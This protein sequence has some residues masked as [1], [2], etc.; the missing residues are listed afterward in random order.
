MSIAIVATLVTVSFFVVMP[1]QMPTVK[2]YMTPGMG[3]IW[4]FDDLVA[5]SGGDVMG[6]GGI[7]VIMNDLI[8]TGGPNPD[9]VYTRDNEVIFV[10]PAVS[11][12]VDGIFLSQGAAG[13]VI[14]E[15]GSISP[16]PGDWGGFWFNVGSLGRFQAT[17]IRHARQGIRITDGDVTV[18]SSIIELCY[19]DAIYF[20]GG[21]LQVNRSVIQGAQPPTS[22]GMNNG[23][24][25]IYA[26]GPVADVLWINQSVIV[27]GDGLPTGPGGPAIF[28]LNLNGPM[29]LIGNDLIQGGAGGLN[30]VDGG[31]AGGGGI[32]F[33][34]FPVWDTG[35]PPLAGVNISGNAI[36]RGGDGGVNNATMDGQSGTGGPGIIMSDND[37]VGT[38]I[39]A[40]N[41]YISGGDGGDNFANANVGFF[42]G[43][44]GVGI[45]WDNI[46]GSP[47][48]PSRISGN[49]I[50][51]GGKGGNN[52]GASMV[53]GLAAG[54]GGTA[55]NFNDVRSVLV[56]RNTIVGGHG[57]N[58]TIMGMGVAAGQG[59]VALAMI[60]SQNVGV[61]QN[62]IFGGEGGDDYVG[63][64]PGMVAGPGPGGIGLYS[65]N[66]FGQV[67][68]NTVQGGEGG[69]NYGMGG[70]GRPGGYGV[71]V[72]GTSAPTFNEGTFRGGKGGDNY[73]DTGS[74][75][76][77]GNYA[78]FIGSPRGVTITNAEIYGGAGGDCYAGANALPGQG[79]SAI[80]VAGPAMG[81]RIADN[82][83]ITVG[84][85]GNHFLIPVTGPKG[86]YGVELILGASGVE[87]MNN[88]IYNASS[89]GIYSQIPGVRIDGN[90]I[91]SDPV[92]MGIYLD[93]T[94]NWTNITNNPMI[95]FSFLG[96]NVLQADDVTIRNNVVENT[97]VGIAII[98]SDRATIDR[99]TVRNVSTWGM[100]FQTF[101]DNV[102]VENCTIENSLT[103]D[104]A[105][106]LWS[107]ATT[108]NTT[109][110][111][112]QVDALPDTRL[113]VKNYLDVR[114]ID[115]TLAPLPNTDLEVLDNAVQV[116]ATPLFGGGDPTTDVS[117]EVN[118]IVVTDRIYYGSP[119]ATENITD[120]QVAE[121]GRTFVNNPRPVDMSVSHEELFYELGADP[122]P[123][124]IQ[125]VLID[126]VKFRTVTP[127]TSVTLNAT[128]NDTLTGNSNITVANY[129]IGPANWP[130]SFM[131]P[132]DGAY[133][134]QVED[135][136]NIID[137]TMWLAGSYELWVYGCDDSGNCNVTGDFATLNITA[138]ID[139]E[140]PEIYNVLVDGMATV[141][142]V[143]GTLVDLSAE[144]N[145]NLTGGSNILFAN[146][147]IGQDNWPG[148][149]MFPLDG[150]YDQTFEYVN[151][152]IDTT[153]WIVGSYEVWVYGCDVIP[154]CNWTG[155]FATINIVLESTPPM[156][157]NVTVNG[158][159]QVDV[160]AGTI[161]TLNATVDDRTTGFSVIA[162][163]NYTMGMANWPGTGMNAQD[164]MWNTAIENVTAQVDT[165]G[166]NCGLFDL[167]VYG[168]DMVPNYNT[169]STAFATINI[170][171]CDYEPPMIQVVR[172]DGAPTQTYPLSALPPTI[173]LTALIN[174]NP[175]GGTAI[176]GANYTSPAANWPGTPMNAMDGTFDS[177]QEDVEATIMTPTVPGVY[178]Y[179]VYG[180]DQ[181]IPPNYNTTGSCATLTI[182]DDVAPNVWNVF[183]DGGSTL[184]VPE[185]TIVTLDADIDDSVTGGSDIWDAYWDFAP[186]TWPG[187]PMNPT[188]GFFDSPTEGVTASIDTTGWAAGSY[189]ICVNSRDVLDNRN[190]TCQNFA[191]LTVTV[192]VDMLPPEVTNVLVD[193][194]A[195]VTVAAGASVTLT[196]TI[197][198]QTTGGS[199][200]A[201]ANYTMGLFN[202]PGVMMSAADG[203]FDNPIE[204]V[205]ATIDT[206]GWAINSYDLCVYGWDVIP[207]YNT[208]STECAQIIIV[209]DVTPPTASGTPTGTA[210]PVTTNITFQFS[211]PMNTA[212]VEASFGYTDLV[213]SWGAADGTF[214]WSNGDTTA[215]FDP[216]TDLDY[217]T[218]YLVRLV[219]SIAED[220]AGNMLDGNADGFGGDN[221]TFAFRTEVEVIAPDTTPPTVTDTDP[222]DG[223]SDVPIDLPTIEVDFDEPM[224]EDVID[225]ELDGIQ[226]QESWD[227]N[228]LVITP[229]EDLEYDTEYTVTITNAE[230]VAGNSMATYDF[231][232]TTETQPEPPAEPEPEEAEV[233]LYWMLI[234]ILI[235]LVIILAILL[236]RKRKPKEEPIPPMAE[237]AMPA[238]EAVYEE[239]MAYEE[240]P[241]A[242]I[243]ELTFEE[244][245]MPAEETEFLEDEEI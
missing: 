217:S 68:N 4:N 241:E 2:A 45:S 216:T 98:G 173:W 223:D 168:W 128:L 102:W 161:V 193:G 144:L 238:E 189:D 99:T 145:D 221:Y 229:L 190:S 94:A 66:T 186:P 56:T 153:A 131:S 109:F 184:T 205:T 64:G 111:G 108:L 67:D 159:P 204:D 62:A 206:T 16:Q 226:T 135:V 71:M 97:D 3:V 207:N 54:S 74:F 146:Y 50:I 210:E 46:G 27:G 215:V 218:T 174:D 29:G 197:D 220:V 81:V 90:V 23:G 219:G 196:A 49:T 233:T 86:S 80:V 15:S 175:T 245:G 75:G 156:I 33:H 36:I 26:E 154:N 141:N 169:T 134:T 123:P 113:T 177:D 143:A 225:V 104:F 139:N 42:V 243:D 149:L 142:V 17:E 117:G 181:V 125:N 10:N 93:P 37:Y 122:E 222:P 132:W 28:T 14:F 211:E 163:A 60:I 112:A 124:E 137:T 239:E 136:Y 237:E 160:P 172:I 176:G 140:P 167:Y 9:T 101:A 147:T 8:V 35:G 234:V 6:G 202:W 244:E 41:A 198:D 59:Q 25:A 209:G 126:G 88:Y 78:F 119:M 77:L 76:G 240:E 82:T 13:P 72:D 38:A 164:G 127:G 22:A 110:N 230:D 224:N 148:I 138:A 43:N 103:W 107:N 44:G 180:W 235:V 228:T 178:D 21:L 95:G 152:T 133:D 155:D 18:R 115:S 208:T 48:F 57:G 194:G 40:G 213:G 166:W 92:G 214:T 91:Q 63:L 191:T 118:W 1:T 201:G 69:D 200:I 195:T 79:Y 165:T 70:E 185:G 188:D 170:T 58:N 39:V 53:I 171:V 236:L 121:G 227:G 120:A 187:T 183:L 203:F 84:Q 32:G 30:N 106:N 55:V 20:E 31:N 5:N 150:S 157:Y 116:Y 158:L 87:I 162:G 47:G 34:A 7:Y 89:A 73:N 114:V 212:T 129:T 51:S 151:A 199:D 83:M 130:G 96:I 179:C 61:M 12:E 105:M 11:I 85:G 19:P 100:R 242:A 65:I 232:F 231:S 182:V 52:S 24:T 192:F